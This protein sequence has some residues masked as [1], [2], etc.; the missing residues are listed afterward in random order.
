MGL[1]SLLLSKSGGSYG[2]TVAHTVV[3][4][5]CEIDLTVTVIP[6]VTT[7]TQHPPLIVCHLGNSVGRMGMGMGLEVGT[8][9]LPSARDE[10]GQLESYLHT[11]SLTIPD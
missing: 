8:Y 3:P 6:T 9:V 1:V 10:D 11:Q 2:P 5:P 7:F 4:R